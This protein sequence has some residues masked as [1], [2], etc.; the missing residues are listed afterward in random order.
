MCTEF[1]HL[2]PSE[3]DPSVEEPVPLHLRGFY[4][5]PTRMVRHRYPG[6]SLSVWNQWGYPFDVSSAAPVAAAPV[7]ITP[8]ATTPVALSPKAKS[9]FPPGADPPPAP[10]AATVR[11]LPRDLRGAG[12]PAPPERHPL[13]FLASVA[14]AGSALRDRSDRRHELHREVWSYCAFVSH[15]RNVWARPTLHYNYTCD[16]WTPGLGPNGRGF[17]LDA[18]H[19]ASIKATSAA[20]R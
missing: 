14:E 15:S 17:G 5:G 11:D 3:P 13:S 7:A 19:W 16:W 10:V 9:W 20:K 6:M 18:K 2:E 12:W 1:A 4:P 8:L